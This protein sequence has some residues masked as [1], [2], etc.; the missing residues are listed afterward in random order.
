M[1]TLS[2]ILFICIV[3]CSAQPQPPAEVTTPT[4]S[5]EEFK[6][7]IISVR[8]KINAQYVAADSL[9]KDSLIR[10]SQEFLR[11]ITQEVFSY[12]YKTQWDFNGITQTPQQGKIACGY[13]V[14]TDGCIANMEFDYSGSSGSKILAFSV[15]D[16]NISSTGY[17]AVLGTISI[18]SR[19]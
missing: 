19:Q 13:F 10:Y 9:G 7:N 4:L 18:A 14:T 6:A 5:Y 8:E 15:E 11:N 16:K 1:R 17:Q 12:W 2:L 3:S